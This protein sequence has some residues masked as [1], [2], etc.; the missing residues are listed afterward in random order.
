MHQIEK[1]PSR[2][3]LRPNPRCCPTRLEFVLLCYSLLSWRSCRCSRKTGEVRIVQSLDPLKSNRCV[4]HHRC[5]VRGLRH[6]SM[7]LDV[8]EP[9]EADNFDVVGFPYHFRRLRC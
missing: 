1:L 5:L 6:E 9:V 2:L 3:Y 8:T 7:T 4:R